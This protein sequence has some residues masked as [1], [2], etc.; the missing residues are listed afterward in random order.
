MVEFIRDKRPESV[1]IP[2]LGCG[3]GGLDWNEVKGIIE[4]NI[5]SG[6]RV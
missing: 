4:K 1:A 5:F 6:R 2:P 3:N